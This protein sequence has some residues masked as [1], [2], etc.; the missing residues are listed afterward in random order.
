MSSNSY[1]RAD[2]S[3]CSEGRLFGPDY[4][5]LPAGHMLMV[6]RITHVASEGG[7]Y[8]KGLLTAELDI[9]PDLWF[10]ECHFRG[11]PVMPGSLGLDALWQLV[12]FFLAWKGYKGKGRA[13]GVEGVRFRGEVLPDAKVVSY[14]IHIRRIINRKLTMGIADG[15]VKVDGETIYTAKDLRVGLYGDTTAG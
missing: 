10:F 3:E 15:I 13:L 12:G 6:D 4:G 1:S 2:V 8:D 7:N 5:K 14:E 11:D 9:T